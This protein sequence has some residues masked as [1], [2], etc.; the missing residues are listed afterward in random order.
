MRGRANKFGR[1]RQKGMD[2][3]INKKKR[4]EWTLFSQSLIWTVG[5]SRANEPE[6]VELCSQTHSVSFSPFRDISSG[7]VTIKMERDTKKSFSSGSWGKPVFTFFQ[8][9]EVNG[10]FWP[11][12]RVYFWFVGCYYLKTA[13]AV[14][15]NSFGTGMGPMPWTINSEIYPMWARSTCNSIATST[16]WFFNLMISMTFLTFMEILGREGE[17]NQ[18]NPVTLRCYLRSLDIGQETKRK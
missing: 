2:K 1:C 3:K 15:M 9:I 17:R 18:P 6:L 8:A 4:K 12:V 11:R 10:K 5:E 14:T 13:I 16:N 7:K